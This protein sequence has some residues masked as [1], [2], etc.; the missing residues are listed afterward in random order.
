MN[1]FV[2]R[3]WLGLTLL[4]ATLVFVAL[5]AHAA[6]INSLDYG[7]R[8]LAK[9][10]LGPGTCLLTR[11]TAA[12]D[13]AYIFVGGNEISIQFEADPDGANAV[14][15]V[16]VFACTFADEDND[17]TKD[18]TSCSPLSIFDSDANGIGDTNRLASTIGQRGTAVPIAIAGWLYYDAVDVT[19]VPEIVTCAQSR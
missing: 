19:N 9:N 15:N 1:E 10:T 5:A 17:G 11:F 7:N 2:R 14:G 6:V 8:S 12:T 16:D 4:V 18:S 13:D 3:Y